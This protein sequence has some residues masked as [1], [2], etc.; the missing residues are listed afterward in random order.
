MTQADRAGSPTQ[1]RTCVARSRR[2]SDSPV[3][4]SA[5]RE[6]TGDRDA[7]GEGRQDRVGA[8]RDPLGAAQQPAEHAGAEPARRRRHRHRPGRGTRTPALPSIGNSGSVPL[9]RRTTGSRSPR[10]PVPA[11]ACGGRSRRDTGTSSANTAPVAG[12][13]KIAATPA[14]APATI[15][16][17]RS[18]DRNRRRARRCVRRRR[19]WRRCTATGPRVPSARR[20]PSVATAATMR[21]ANARQPELVARLMEAAKVLVRRRR[22]DA[23]ADPPTR[24]PAPRAG[25]RPGAPRAATAAGR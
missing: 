23:A 7:G 1:A 11:A 12:A 14:A 16:V 2:T 22:G 3:S 10:R 4:A 5:D 9:I 8:V 21:P 19:S 15:S 24:R 25:R 20:T 13:L 17:R 6:Q 18:A